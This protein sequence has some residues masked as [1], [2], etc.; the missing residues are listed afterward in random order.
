MPRYVLCEEIR[1]EVAADVEMWGRGNVTTAVNERWN[2]YCF[3]LELLDVDG[4]LITK[5]EATP[6]WLHRGWSWD[7]CVRYFEKIVDSAFNDIEGEVITRAEA[8]TRW[9]SEGYSYASCHSYFRKNR[10]LT[11]KRG[12]GSPS[13]G[14]DAFVAR[15]TEEYTGH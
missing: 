4:H 2:K 3:G 11:V 12:H 15:V 13:P 14:F 10:Q 1:A 9:Q 8:F 6:L 7:Q 5:A